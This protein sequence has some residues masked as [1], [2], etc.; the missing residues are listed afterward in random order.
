MSDSNCDNCERLHP[1]DGALCSSCEAL[2][3][4]AR[5][6]ERVRL[7]K[8]H[9][10]RRV[11]HENNAKN[12]RVRTTSKDQQFGAAAAHGASADWLRGQAAQPEPSHHGKSVEHGGLEKHRGPK[13]ACPAPDCA[14]ES[15]TEMQAKDDARAKALAGLRKLQLI[16]GLG[17]TAHDI[18]AEAIRALEDT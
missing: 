8:W 7:A 6:D 11:E 10:Q 18:I 9:D 12:S 15:F 1:G 5:A 17:Y 4:A 14:R 16:G 3:S 13:E 2:D